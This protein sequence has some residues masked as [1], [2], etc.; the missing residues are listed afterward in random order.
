MKKVPG[1][2]TREEHRRRN[3][4]TEGEN[5]DLRRNTEQEQEETNAEER[6][7]RMEDTNQ[8]EQSRST[9]YGTDRNIQH[10]YTTRSGNVAVTAITTGDKAICMHWLERIKQKL[11]QS[12]QSRIL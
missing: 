10:W 5:R 4:K 7:R 2:T 12:K 8:Q 3:E 9:E 1:Q 6:N 11:V